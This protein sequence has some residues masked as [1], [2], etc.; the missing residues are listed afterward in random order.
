MPQDIWYL[1]GLLSVRSQELVYDRF[2]LSLSPSH[3]DTANYCEP[4]ELMTRNKIAEKEQPDA[5]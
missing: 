1:H 2:R 3:H 4:E 5:V